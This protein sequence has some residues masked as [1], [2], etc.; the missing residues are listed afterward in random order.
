MNF[1]S[2]YYD[3]TKEIEIYELRL[4]DLEQELKQARKIMFS[5]Q[6]PSDPLPVHVPL[7]KALDQYDRV[8]AKIRETSD[9]LTE[10]KMIRQRIEENIKDFKGIEHQVAYMRDILDMPLSRIADELG[11]S[12]SFISKISSR[13]KSAKRV[14]NSFAKS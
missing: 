4:M 2:M 8:V 13:I 10:K 5:G 11:Y 7:D 1:V 3:I 14:Q 9:R 12:Y 6:L